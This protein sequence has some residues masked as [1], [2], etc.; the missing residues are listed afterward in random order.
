MHYNESKRL[1]VAKKTILLEERFNDM[2][3]DIMLNVYNVMKEKGISFAELSYI[4]GISESHLYRVL[5]GNSQ[6]KFD[7]FCKIIVALD[8]E[9]QEIFPKEM[10]KRQ[11]KT[12]YG[13]C[14]EYIVRNMDDMEKDFL[15]GQ[16]EQYA[17]HQ[18]QRK[19]V[20]FVPYD[21][22][23]SEGEGHD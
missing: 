8:I 11:E 19:E 5:R 18:E 16:A 4:T 9:P 21:M 3:S 2:Y 15:L 6:V 10:Q 13:E 14:F 12:E 1:Y 7:S 20:R 22:D 17:M 23:A